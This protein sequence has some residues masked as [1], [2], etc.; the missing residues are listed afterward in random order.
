MGH[1]Y[2]VHVLSAVV[3][4]KLITPE[5]R[6]HLIVVASYRLILPL[7]DKLKCCPIKDD[8][9]QAPAIFIDGA[10]FTLRSGR[11]NLPYLKHHRDVDKGMV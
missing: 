3:P 2:V 9:H 4:A 11:L 7:Y 8:V 10:D 6:L 1:G 5:S